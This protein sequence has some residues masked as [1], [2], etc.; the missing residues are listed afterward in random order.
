MKDIT[1]SNKPYLVY[2]ILDKKAPPKREKDKK[3]VY[4]IFQLLCSAYAWVEYKAIR[5]LFISIYPSNLKETPENLYPNIMDDKTNEYYRVLAIQNPT[6]KSLYH[7][8]EVFTETE[9][10]IV[11]RKGEKTDAQMLG[12]QKKIR[13]EKIDAGIRDE[14]KQLRAGI[15]NAW[16]AKGYEYGWIELTKE[17]TLRRLPL[18]VPPFA[19][20]SPL[21]HPN[22]VHLRKGK[23]YLSNYPLRRSVY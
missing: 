10:M 16:N 21:T 20:A 2:F 18:C 17:D 5:R 19:L 8:E 14:L 7:L 6:D 1:K 22:I 13:S 12:K 9:K 3:Y 23:E 4:S 11:L 15:L